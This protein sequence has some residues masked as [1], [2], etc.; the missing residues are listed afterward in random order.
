MGACYNKMLNVARLL[1]VSLSSSCCSTLTLLA[2]SD[3]CF[4][5]WDEHANLSQ[6]WFS[7]RKEA[8]AAAEKEPLLVSFIY[9]TIL[10]QRTLEDAVAFHLANKVQ[11]QKSRV[12]LLG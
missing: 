4:D 10:N 8:R 2:S 12:H 9:S 1:N 7:M 6:V 5:A 11:H 3:A